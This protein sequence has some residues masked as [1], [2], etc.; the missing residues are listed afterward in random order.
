MACGK[1][2]IANRAPKTITSVLVLTL[3][4]DEVLLELIEAEAK[5]EARVFDYR[6]K[7]IHRMRLY[8]NEEE[9]LCWELAWPPPTSSGSKPSRSFWQFF[10][11]PTD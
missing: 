9:E 11:I 1:D 5:V 2:L 8:C 3:E 6:I 4:K 10:K 7:Q